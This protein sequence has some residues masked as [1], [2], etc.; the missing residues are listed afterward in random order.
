MENRIKLAF[1]EDWNKIGIAVFVAASIFFLNPIPLLVGFGLEIA[2][3]LFF[4]DSK[5]YEDILV[6]RH[7]GGILE[8]RMELKHKVLSKASQGFTEGYL[9]LEE[10]RVRLDDEYNRSDDWK[11]VID[12]LDLLLNKYL[13]FAFLKFKLEGYITSLSEQAERQVPEMLQAN[14]DASRELRKRLRASTDSAAQYNDETVRWVEERMSYI[15]AYFEGQVISIEQLVKEEEVRVATGRGNANNLD[16]L[17]KRIDIQNMMLA[18]AEKM[19]HGLV[20]LNQQMSLMAETIRLI[21][22]QITS[23]QPG[24]VLL[25]VENLVDQSETVSNFLQDLTVFDDTESQQIL[26]TR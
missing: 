21:N 19:G 22:G 26:L 3:L 11:S 6:Q 4:P 12:R 20:N 18:Q 17:R 2:Y 5:W 24:Q 8:R 7:K 16:T 9:E 13:E 14:N 1:N 15:R 23:K 25:D 10:A